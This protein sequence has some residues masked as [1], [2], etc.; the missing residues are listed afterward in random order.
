MA[1]S[2]KELIKERIGQLQERLNEIEEEEL[3]I[4]ACAKD[5]AYAENEHQKEQEMIKR[6]NKEE[7]EFDKAW[8]A[9]ELELILKYKQDDDDRKKY[10]QEMLN[11]RQAEQTARI[12]LEFQREKEIREHTC[13]NCGKEVQEK[14]AH[15]TGGGGGGGFGQTEYVCAP[16]ATHDGYPRYK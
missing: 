4:G 8:N 10:E 7:K 16:K 5:I 15:F 14:Y 12:M 2:E 13:E 3:A 1:K 9:R 6:I 11:K